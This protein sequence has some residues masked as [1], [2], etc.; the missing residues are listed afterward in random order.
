VRRRGSGVAQGF[1]R[2]FHRQS[3]LM[4]CPPNS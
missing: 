4:A 3:F 1:H 2:R